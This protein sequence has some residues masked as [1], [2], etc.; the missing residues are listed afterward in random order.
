LGWDPLSPL[1][2]WV[3]LNEVVFFFSEHVRRF[4]PVAKPTPLGGNNRVFSLFSR[5]NWLSPFSDK[6]PSFF[7]PDL[8]RSFF[9]TLEGLEGGFFAAWVTPSWVERLLQIFL[10]GSPWPLPLILLPAYLFLGFHY[11]FFFPDGGN[12]PFFRGR[13]RGRPLFQIRLSHPLHRCAK[14]SLCTAPFDVPHAAESFFLPCGCAFPF[15]GGRF[16]YGGPVC[17]KTMLFFPAC[18]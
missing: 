3:D 17:L 10:R 14:S 7:G 15:K 5:W 11:F 6:K 9:P 8:I 18:A 2:S 13:C 4:P 1:K 16:S 12:S